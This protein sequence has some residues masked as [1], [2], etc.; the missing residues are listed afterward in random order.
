MNIQIKLLIPVL[1]AHLSSPALADE[2][3][4]SAVAAK[5]A[6]ASTAQLVSSFSTA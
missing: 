4:K 2:E 6:T 5:A 3:G 1:V